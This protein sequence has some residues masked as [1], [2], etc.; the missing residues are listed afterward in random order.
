MKILLYNMCLLA[1]YFWLW[2]YHFIWLISIHK[3]DF[4]FFLLMLFDEWFY[5]IFRLHL[6]AKLLYWCIQWFCSMRQTLGV[7]SEHDEAPRHPLMYQI[8]HTFE[9]ECSCR[10]TVRS[11]P[12]GTRWCQIGGYPSF[13][14]PHFFLYLFR[15]VVGGCVFGWGKIDYVIY[16]RTGVFFPLLPR[17]SRWHL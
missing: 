4:R 16:S 12:H 11:I 9:T 2:N 14:L 7:L 8:I 15:Y 13:S 6:F 1:L 10:S 5:R 17:N 3:I